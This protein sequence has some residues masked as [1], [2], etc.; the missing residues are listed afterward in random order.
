M[1]SRNCWHFGLDFPESEHGTKTLRFWA[2]LEARLF[3]DV[4]QAR[5]LYGELAKKCTDDYLLWVEYINFER[6]MG[7]SDKARA[8]FRRVAQVAIPDVTLRLRSWSDWIAF[9]REV[10]SIE[11][12]QYAADQ[13]NIRMH[14]VK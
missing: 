1:A 11:Q 2:G 13:T 9:E 8:L 5:Y 6:Y 7:E 12:Q 4:A 3:R 10:G 14:E